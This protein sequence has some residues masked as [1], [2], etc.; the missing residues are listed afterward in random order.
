MAKYGLTGRLTTAPGRGKS[1]ANGQSK[2]FKTKVDFQIG[3]GGTTA[4]A[5]GSI[6]TVKTSGKGLGSFGRQGKANTP[7]IQ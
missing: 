3:R 1:L 4:G 2:R 5:L 6:K 7:G